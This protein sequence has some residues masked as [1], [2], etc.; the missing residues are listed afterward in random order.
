MKILIPLLFLA[1]LAYGQSTCYPCFIDND[2]YINHFEFN[3]LF[4]I[5]SNENGNYTVYGIDEFTT[6]VTLGETYSMQVASEETW[7]FPSR[8]TAWIDFDN[9]GYFEPGEVVLDAG[10]VDYK[11][12]LVTIPIDSNFVGIRR[13]RIMIGES[14]DTLDPCGFYNSGE[15]E[16]YF[17]T[18]TNSYV[19]PCY[20]TPFIYDDFVSE[21]EDFKV[22]DILN[23]NSECDQ[24]SYYSFYPDSIFSTD[25][26]IGKTYRI[27]VSKGTNAGVPAGIRA[28]IDFNN[29]HVFSP[30]ELILAADDAGIVDS[31]FTLPNDSNLIG[32]H[33]L[34]ARISYWGIPNSGCEWA[35]GE[36]EDYI[37][38]IIP[39]DTTNG[40]THAW[41]KIIQLP[42]S[43]GVYD[44]KE[45]YDKGYAISLVEGSDMNEFRLIKFSIDG[46]TL[47]S[48]FPVSDE[49]YYPFKMF[50]TYDGGHVICG[51]TL[52]NEEYGDPYVMKLNACGDLQWK[53]TYGNLTNF[54][55]ATNIIQSSDSNYVVLIRY[56]SDTSRIALFKIDSIGTVIWQNDYTYH[57]DSEPNDLIETSDKGYLITG[58]TYTPNPGDTNLL[59][60]RGMVIKVDSYGN[61]QWEKVIGISD[62]TV[63]MSFSSVELESGGFFISTSTL[64]LETNEVSSGVYK[65]DKY[66]NLL[67]YKRIASINDKSVNANFILRMDDNKYCIVSRIYCS[68]F[69]N[70]SMLGLYMIDSAANVLDSTFVDDYYL[71]IQGAVVTENNKIV[72]SGSKDFPDNNYDIFMYKFNEDLDF[73]SLYCINLTY[74]SLCDIIIYQ[75]ELSEEN[76]NL[77]LFPNPTCQGIN[78]QINESEELMYLVEIISI[79]GS[80][81]KRLNIKS[82]ELKYFSLDDLNS[83]IYLITISLNNQLLSSRKIVKSR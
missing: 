68:C 40:N 31:Y 75:P 52:E 43:Q 82:N 66:G 74:D 50:E 42:G 7:I 20:C 49:L 39:Q 48:K 26:E 5:Q 32:E 58:Y 33:R 27:L 80:V 29:D 77:D 81:L 51:L 10:E 73:D 53:K 63:C 3:S 17:I 70:T 34:R 12:V 14:P 78:I 72:V 35:R 6:S 24:F 45:T 46:D 28:F 25:L 8:Y 23:C 67:D 65:I 38:N 59:W 62:T 4:N 16:D 61:E 37:I 60:L 56:L 83:G 44:I 71:V 13:L 21:I 57:Y 9:D 54:D 19:E 79:N 64:D 30:S 2:A 36:T 1:S 55:D 41:Q 18:I 11:N 22:G 47:W 69:S 15:A 76:I